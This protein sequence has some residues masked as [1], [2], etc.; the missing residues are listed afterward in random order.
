MHLHTADTGEQNTHVMNNETTD[1]SLSISRRLRSPA[2]AS[3]A[4]ATAVIIGVAASAWYGPA[5]ARSD[6]PWWQKK[7]SL[8]LQ[9]RR[10][11]RREFSEAFT[12]KLGPEYVTSTPYVS[13][14][15]IDGLRQAIGKYRK[16]VAT[17][18][19]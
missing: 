1:K 4:L 3:I 16:M 7:R 5:H 10:K 17:G 8:T 19:W 14:Q 15:T 12:A 11:Q 2:S 6:E 18:G 9:E 13:Q